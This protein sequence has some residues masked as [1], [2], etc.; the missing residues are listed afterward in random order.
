MKTVSFCELLNQLPIA[1]AKVLANDPDPEKRRMASDMEKQVYLI[2]KMMG[3]AGLEEANKCIAKAVKLANEI[4]GDSGAAFLVQY[5]EDNR[6]IVK[7]IGNETFESAVT[8]AI[9]I[10]YTALLLIFVFGELSDFLARKFVEKVEHGS[11]WDICNYAPVDA[12]VAY[13]IYT[14]HTLSESERIK[15]TKREL[16]RIAALAR[17][18]ENIK[19]RNNGFAW[20]DEKWS[21]YRSDAKTAEEMI[22]IFKIGY[23][24]ALDWIKLWKKDRKITGRRPKEN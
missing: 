12:H 23:N 2:I 13:S 14:M 5:Q 22:S 8:D 17:N 6:E 15:K 3:D 18:A 10:S 21:S 20:L 4:S 11:V 1:L 19:N 9:G 16:A 24:T 7:E